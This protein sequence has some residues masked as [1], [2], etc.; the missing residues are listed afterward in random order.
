VHPDADGC[1]YC[2]L[3]AIGRGCRFAPEGIHVHPTTDRCMYC[4]STAIGRG[5][6]FSPTG[7]HQ[8]YPG[9]S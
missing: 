7:I 9:V 2:G 6:R 1:V 8:R 3:P 4:G 5:C